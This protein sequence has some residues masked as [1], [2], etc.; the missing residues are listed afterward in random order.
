TCG[1]GYEAL[2][3]LESDNFNLVIIDNHMPKMNGVE[4]VKKIREAGYKDVIIIGWTADIMQTST[5]AFIKAGA[6]EVLTKPLIKRDLI[7]A[8]SRHLNDIKT[9][10]RV[11]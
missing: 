11:G 5:H 3:L 10:T 2:S 4:T 1:D 8:L 9:T 6:N 7:E